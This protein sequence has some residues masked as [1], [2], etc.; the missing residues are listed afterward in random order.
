MMRGIRWQRTYI[1]ETTSLFA[2]AF[3]Q[4]IQHVALGRQDPF[5]VVPLRVLEIDDCDIAEGAVVDG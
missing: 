4:A 1:H 3:E 5:L 2:P